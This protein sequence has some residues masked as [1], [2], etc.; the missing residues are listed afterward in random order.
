MS[1]RQ[2]FLQPDFI[3]PFR[4]FGQFSELRI[5]VTGQRG[6]LGRLLTQRFIHAGISVQLYPGDI[7]D[8]RVLR[9][10]ISQ[11]SFDLF[12]HLAAIV[13]I[14]KVDRDPKRAF[15]VNAIGAYRVCEYLV[16]TQH[17][18]W[19]FFASTSH[20][21]RPTT[22][23]V[24]QTLR[25][26]DSETPS[27][28]YGRTKLAGEHLCRQYLEAHQKRYCIARIFSYSHISQRGPYLVPRIIQKIKTLT[29][30]KPLVIANPTSVRDIV[31]AE[32]VVDSI[33]YLA[34]SRFCGTV[35]IGSGSG[36]TISNIAR[37]VAVTLGKN[38]VIKSEAIEEPNQ[39]V[40]DVTPLRQ[41]IAT[42][43]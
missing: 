37:H 17:Q 29:P 41:I 15:E 8:Y 3:P 11:R 7:T 10:W 4:N 19:F 28:I 2:I 35:N 20:V 22:P 38:I 24:A 43:L 25:V 39:F 31:D 21:Y 9:R 40:A 18:C 42:L 14:A 16:N 34:M 26:G 13:P 12:F 23:G 30:H 6:V 32:T 5:G 27:S 1:R 36:M 33:L